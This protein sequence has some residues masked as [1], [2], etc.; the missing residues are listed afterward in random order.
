MTYLEKLID[1][2]FRT[3]VYGDYG[4]NYTFDTGFVRN[5]KDSTTLTMAVPGLGKE[6]I[7]LEVKDD[8]VLSLTFLKQSDLFSHKSRS[9]TLSED[10][11]VENI[12]AECKD[13]MLTVTL[14]KLKRLPSTRKISIS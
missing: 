4:T 6:D 7:E 1:N 12:T 3:S 8:G 9:W 14:P 2:A 11:D 10:I 5:N 13:G